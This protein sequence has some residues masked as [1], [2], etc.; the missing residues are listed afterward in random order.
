MCSD[1]PWVTGRCVVICD[2]TSLLL[3]V[4]GVLRMSGYSVFQAPIARPP[5]GCA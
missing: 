2:Y 3:S 1:R 4:T 5:K